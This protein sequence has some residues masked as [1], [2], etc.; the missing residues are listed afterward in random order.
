LCGDSAKGWFRPRS[1]TGE[2]RARTA[3][4]ACWD[5][6]P[7]RDIGEFGIDTAM[8]RVTCTSDIWIGAARYRWYGKDYPCQYTQHFGDVSFAEYARIGYKFDPDR[9]AQGSHLIRE[10]CDS[11]YHL[12]GSCAIGSVPQTSVVDNRLRAHGLKGLCVVD[13][14]IFP[15]VTS[16]NINA[17]VMMVVVMGADLVLEDARQVAEP[18]PTARTAQRAAV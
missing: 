4:C 6:D 12:C 1:R 7:A 17:A 15:K 16:G 8:L 10:N 13:A 9:Q 14:S 18:R 3:P 11:I 5:H 2:H